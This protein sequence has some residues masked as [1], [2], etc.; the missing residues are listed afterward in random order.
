MNNWPHSPQDMLKTAG[1]YMVTAAT[2]LK[3]HYF[4]SDSKLEFLENNLLSLARTYEWELHAW[5]VFCNH[6]HFIG[7]SPQDSSTL[8]NYLS[9]LHTKTAVEMNRSDAGSK[10]VVSILG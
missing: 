6:Y 9:E 4:D 7:K 3:A 5:A 2:Y 1:V 10:S 8:K